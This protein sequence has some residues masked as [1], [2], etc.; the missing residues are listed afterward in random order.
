[1]HPTPQLVFVYGTLRR[2]GSN[3]FRMAGAEFIA[4][5]TVAGRMY[6]IDWYP[7]LVLDDAGD[8]IHGEVYSVGPELLAS[9]DVFEGLSAGEIKGSEYRR[10]HA[11]VMRRDSQPVTA[12]V[13]EWIGVTEE[14]SRISDGDWLR[15]E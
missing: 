11:T 14:I 6:R 8:E 2:G 3:H 1:M 4:P 7:G 9:L 10:V 5:G 12:W 15:H 13:W